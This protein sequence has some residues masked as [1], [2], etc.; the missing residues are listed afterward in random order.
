MHKFHFW[1]RIC[2]CWK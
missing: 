1:F 2:F